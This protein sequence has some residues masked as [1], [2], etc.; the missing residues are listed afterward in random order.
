MIGASSFELEYFNKTLKIL[1]P[2]NIPCRKVNYQLDIILETPSFDDII[3]NVKNTRIAP[4]EINGFGLFC[5]L[6]FKEASILTILDGQLV[7]CELVKR[8]GNV[9][10]EWNA[11]P[12]NKILLRP[13][14]TKYYY[15]NHSRTPNAK[16]LVNSDSQVCV[17]TMRDTLKDEEITLDYRKEPLPEEYLLTHGATYL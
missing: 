11:L 15:M 2:F 4:S 9:P 5:L 17:L 12:N 1:I 6:P 3:D 8:R 14:K 10:W 16:V 7:D 13:Y